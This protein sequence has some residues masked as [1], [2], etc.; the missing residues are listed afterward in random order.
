MKKFY[1]SP[2]TDVVLVQ[3]DGQLLQSV[4]QG[5]DDQDPLAREHVGWNDD[6][7]DKDWKED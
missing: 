1:E 7:D 6:W 5:D 4:S 2:K 3:L